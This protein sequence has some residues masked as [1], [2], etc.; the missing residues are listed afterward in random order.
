MKISL[1][2]AWLFVMGF[3]MPIYAQDQLLAQNPDEPNQFGYFVLAMSIAIVGSFIILKIKK[4]RKR[5]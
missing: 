5:K 4:W 3:A 2:V 1:L